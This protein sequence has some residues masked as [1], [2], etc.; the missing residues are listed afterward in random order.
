MARGRVG[1]NEGTTKRRGDDGIERRI[2]ASTEVA[3]GGD[4]YHARSRPRRGRRHAG[5]VAWARVARGGCARRFVIAS[6][7]VFGTGF[8]VVDARTHREVAVVD[9][10]RDGA[11][12]S[13]RHG[14]DAAF[15]RAT[16]R[17]RAGRSGSLS[18]GQPVREKRC[19]ATNG[20][21]ASGRSGSYCSE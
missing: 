3:R 21:I 14:V 6:G 7:S 2:G 20:I 15:A 16:R 1:D 13:L 10:R 8:G 19:A 11:H 9:A 18:E 17:S 4:G 5:G 12:I